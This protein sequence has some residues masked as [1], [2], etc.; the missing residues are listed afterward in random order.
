MLNRTP[1][2]SLDLELARARQLL[3]A[4]RREEAMAMALVLLQQALGHLRTNLLAFQDNLA[5]LKET[6]NQSST[7][8]GASHG[9]YPGRP[10]DGGGYYH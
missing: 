2:A 6:P 8:P 5:R 7:Q 1:S 10:P 3:A 4:G 9:D